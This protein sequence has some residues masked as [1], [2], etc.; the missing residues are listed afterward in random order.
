MIGD[1]NFGSTIVLVFEAPHSFRYKFKP[2]DKVKYGQ[3]LGYTLD[4]DDSS[5]EN[6][7]D[8]IH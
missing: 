5:S 7:A 2:G 4:A 3:G 8:V 1:F 6:N